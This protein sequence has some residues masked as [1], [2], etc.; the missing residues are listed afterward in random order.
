ME[1]LRKSSTRL[2]PSMEAVSPTVTHSITLIA[3]SHP[4]R[5]AQTRTPRHNTHKDC[6]SHPIQDGSSIA[7]I[8]S[9][10]CLFFLLSQLTPSP[11]LPS[12]P[13]PPSPPAS[14]DS[15]CNQSTAGSVVRSRSTLV[16]R[17]CNEISVACSCAVTHSPTCL[18]LLT[19]N[20][21]PLRN[22]WTSGSTT[23]TT[24]LSGRT[25]P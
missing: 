12:S 13:A 21:L 24:S 1:E 17:L 7:P 8:H 11:L 5:L 2:C 19:E 23:T 9:L 4:M 25:T 6:T 3:H 16:S 15:R 10:H 14:P 22:R 18:A 20:S